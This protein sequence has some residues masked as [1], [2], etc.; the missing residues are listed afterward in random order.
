MDNR[1]DFEDGTG[2][3]AAPS[4][5]EFTFS[6]S[7]TAGVIQCVQKGGLVIYSPTHT[8]THTHTHTESQEV[9]IRL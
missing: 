7:R 9:F 5:L 6:N 1:D 2:R 4:A 3:T 8:H